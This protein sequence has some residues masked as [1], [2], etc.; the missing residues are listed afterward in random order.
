MGADGQEGK[1]VWDILSMHIKGEH[2]GFEQDL[3]WGV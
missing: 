2:L 1:A 3:I